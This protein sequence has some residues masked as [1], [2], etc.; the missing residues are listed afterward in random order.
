LCLRADCFWYLAGT[1]S[2]CAYLLWLVCACAQF[3]CGVVLYLAADAGWL[4][5]IVAAAMVLRVARWEHAAATSSL[6]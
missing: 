3:V 6:A 1:G 4:H 5:G 2:Y